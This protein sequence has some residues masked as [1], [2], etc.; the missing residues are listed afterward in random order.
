VNQNG[1]LG[2][3]KRF[4]RVL[5]PTGKTTETTCLGHKLKN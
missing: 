2:R 5:Y 1:M 4:D 3:N